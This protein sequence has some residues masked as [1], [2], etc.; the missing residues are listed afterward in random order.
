MSR[1]VVVDPRVAVK[2]L[3]KEEDVA[4]ALRLLEGAEDITAPQSLF[5]EVAN[6]L[7]KK[8]RRG[9]VSAATGQE[10]PGALPGLSAPPSAPMTFRARRS[11][12]PWRPTAPSATASMGTT[13]TGWT[14]RR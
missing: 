10:A 6:A 12:W 2:W 3:V 13:P 11:G 14:A 1:P 7:W 4:D 8:V 9:E 5:G